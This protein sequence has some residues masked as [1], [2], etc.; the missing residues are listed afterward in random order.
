MAD[1]DGDWHAHPGGHGPPQTD[2]GPGGLAQGGCQC[3]H[4]QLGV[5][6]RWGGHWAVSGHVLGGHHHRDPPARHG[7]VQPG[8]G[9]GSVWVGGGHHAHWGCFLSG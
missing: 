1:G 7:H 2:C 6:G 9:P 5:G 8:Q 4:L 3:G